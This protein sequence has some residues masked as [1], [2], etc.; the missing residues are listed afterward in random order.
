VTE[1]PI[2]FSDAMVRAILAG[3]KT[4]TRRV[5]MT[6]EPVDFIGPSG[7]EDDPS[8]WGW[9]FDGPDHHGYMVLGRGHDERHD[10]GRISIPCPYGQPGDRLWVREAF[11][12]SQRDP[13]DTS[14][15]TR[16]PQW[17][18]PP[19]Y[20]A[21]GDPGGEW[22]RFDGG[23]HVPIRPPW[24]SARYM[25]RWASRLALEITSVRVERVQS[26]SEEDAR[27]EGVSAGPSA[28]LAETPV[29]VSARE[30]FAEL[31]ESLNGERPGCSWGANP[32]VW[33]VAFRKVRL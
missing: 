30:A 4:Q 24:R 25:P 7:T 18:D 29:G 3:A 13:E 11:A 27:A 16:E 31:W 9:F 14:V 33:V 17:W 5:V 2:L 6:R 28:A 10:H 32:W 19:V 1:R 12:L 8:E 22:T 26:I 21:D 20:R 23:R 15:S